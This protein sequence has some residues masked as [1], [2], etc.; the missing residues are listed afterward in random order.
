MWQAISSSRR[1]IHTPSKDV[2]RSIS[3]MSIPVHGH[4]ARRDTKA[5]AIMAIS[6]R[7][8]MQTALGALSARTE[9]GQ[10]DCGMENGPKAPTGQ[11]PIAEE[12]GCQAATSLRAKRQAV[13][14]R[15]AA[16]VDP[17]YLTG[18]LLSETLV[19]LCS[20]GVG[21]ADEGTLKSLH[22]GRRLGAAWASCQRSKQ[23]LPRDTKGTLGVASAVQ[24]GQPWSHMSVIGD[25]TIT[26]D[27]TPPQDLSRLPSRLHQVSE[28][29]QARQARRARR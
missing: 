14:H 29:R 21:S 16:P 4:S 2:I 12:A 7:P 8:I 1:S 24:P 11:T 6:Y 10:V 23:S 28:A 13:K 25:W 15:R 19:R 17:A 20:G 22:G 9:V 18:Q 5:T 27:P 3:S 26:P